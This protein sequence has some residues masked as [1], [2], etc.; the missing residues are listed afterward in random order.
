MKH[1]PSRFTVAEDATG[2]TTY[3]TNIKSALEVE[4]TSVAVAVALSDISGISRDESDPLYHSIDS[5]SLDGLFAFDN[6]CLRE[7]I[8][9]SFEVS[10]YKINISSCGTLV[11]TVLAS[12]NGETNEQ[13]QENKHRNHN[14]NRQQNQ[15]RDTTA[16]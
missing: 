3:T 2:Q 7:N 10:G 13:T 5:D 16:D 4:Q 9:V 6:N 14:V 12:A 1:I 8:S 11:I 15:R